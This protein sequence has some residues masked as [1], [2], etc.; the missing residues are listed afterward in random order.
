MNLCGIFPNPTDATSLYR[1]IG[2]VGALRRSVDNFRVSLI[3]RINWSVLALHDAVLLQRPNKPAHLD[4]ANMAHAMGVPVWVDYD[5]DPFNVPAGNP[6]AA[7]WNS[8]A[9]RKLVATLLAKADIVTVSTQKLAELFAPLTK[10][11]PRRIPNAHNLE[12]FGPL[13]H[14]RSKENLIM[15]RG[16]ETHLR[17]LMSVGEQFISVSRTHLNWTWFF[18][19]MN[20]WMITEQMPHDNTIVAPAVDPLEYFALLRRVRPQILVVPLAPNAFN[21][22][23]SNIAWLEATYAGAVCL[24]PEMDEWQRPG[25]LRYSSPKHFGQVLEQMMAGD[26]DLDAHWAASKAYI[27]EHLLLEHTNRLRAGVLSDLIALR[28]N[29]AWREHALRNQWARDERGAAAQGVQDSAAEPAA[30][31]PAFP[32]GRKVR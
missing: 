22:A 17:D 23:K 10:Q 20:A 27:E 2:P 14:A 18:C 7:Q 5:D 12:A 13:A 8:D 9:T 1:G 3:D 31:A 24:A 11:P 19:G 25:V 4:A 30:P 15:W 26:I 28:E 6:A 16:S 21:A 29:G 32:L